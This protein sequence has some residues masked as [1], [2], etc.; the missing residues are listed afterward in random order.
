MKALT[1]KQIAEAVEGVL[2]GPVGSE[3]LLVT[4]VTTDSRTAKAGSLF[5]PLRGETFDGHDFILKALEGGAVCAFSQ[6]PVEGA[7]C[8]IRVADTLDALGRLAAYYRSLFRIPIIAIT[9][10]VGKTTTKDI[11]A[12]VLEQKYRVLKTEGNYNN[13]I[14]VPLTLFRLEEFHQAAVVE[15]GMSGFGEIR[16][17]AEIA[18]PDIAVITNI[19]VSHIENLGSRENIMRAKCEIFDYLKKGGVAVLNADDDLLPQIDGQ[20]PFHKRWYGIRNQRDL[21]ATEIVPVGITG[22]RCTVHTPHGSFAAE[23]PLPGEHMVLNA[24]AAAAV[25][26]DMGLTLQEIA[27]G[28]AGFVPTKMRMAI[29]KTAA[30]MTIMND[31]YNANP[32]SMKAAID[33]LARAEGRK[34]AILGDMFELGSYA[35][36]MH[37][38][39]G[40]YALEK[41]IDVL[42]CIGPNARYMAEAPGAMHYETQEEF[43]NKGLAF[44][45]KN[46]TIL[47]KASRGMHF[48]RTVEKIQEVNESA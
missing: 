19:G 12:S 37:R 30:G 8:L 40:R 48:E 2:E 10:S 23:I 15:M 28:I 34:V 17:L 14:G 18:R 33:V 44:L 29:T 32:V 47:V 20:I 41:G 25:G 1:L 7:H 39:V 46:D 45:Q 3:D 36:E 42:V 11:I 6:R 21:Y 4:E 13:H 5:I 22:S 27:A 9:G 38:E 26:M 35:E 43:W 31:A 16:H 24:L